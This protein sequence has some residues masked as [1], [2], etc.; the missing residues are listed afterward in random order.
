MKS[1]KSSGSFEPFKDLDDLLRNQSI[2]LFPQPTGLTKNSRNAAKENLT[3]SSLFSIDSTD[4]FA[5]KDEI[6]CNEASCNDNEDTL[7]L[8]AMVDVKPLSK[9]SRIVPPSGT[10]V[11]P[12]GCNNLESDHESEILLRLNKLIQHGEGFV[13]AQTSEYVEWT[14][15]NVSPLVTR[16]L[17]RGDFTIQGFVDLHGLAVQEAKDTFD[18]FLKDAIT[19]GK[20]AVLIV[21]GRG[22]SSP[23]KP[24]LK[25]KVYGWLTSGEFKKWIVAFSSARLCDG[26]AG[27]TVVL[28]RHHPLPK[29]LRKKR[30][31]NVLDKKTQFL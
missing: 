14:G 5:S 7:F 22:L 15:F 13:V 19:T 1:L 6:S 25:S 24:V 21:H 18:A 9:G 11:I 27:A 30:C 20:H 3:R 12:S 4:L 16:R 26:G 17:H 2:D 23:S 8:Q 10:H 28:L 31:K 29:R